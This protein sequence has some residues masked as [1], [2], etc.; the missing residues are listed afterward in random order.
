MELNQEKLFELLFEA[1]G[2]GIILV[3]TKGIIQM[4]NERV[5]NMFG[6]SK[7]EL[8]G[9]HL[10]IFV[11]KPIRARHTEHLQKYFS[12]PKSRYMGI[13]LHLEAA[14]KDDGLF[15]VEISLNHFEAAGNTYVIALITDVTERKLQEQKILK[16]NEELEQ[17]V[18][19][20]TEQLS[21]SEQLY[22]TIA[23]NF[24]DG[25]INVFDR[26]YNYLFVEGK[27]FLNPHT[28]PLSLTGTNF[29]KQLP[30]NQHEAVTACLEKAFEGKSC[31]VDIKVVDKF[32]TMDTTPLAESD[33]SIPKV[34]SIIKNI[35]PL[36]QTEIK[37]K[38]NLQKERELNR[39]KFRF[40]SMASHEFRTPLSTILSSV[41]L[42]SRY[43]KEEDQAKR[44]KH[45]NRIKSS[46]SNLTI[47]LNDFLSIEK[48]ESGRITVKTETFDLNHIC[49]QVIEDL[50]GVLKKGQDIHFAPAQ[51]VHMVSLDKQLL[52]N[53]IINLLSNASKYSDEDQEIVLKIERA[54]DQS[55]SIHVIDRG[56]GIPESEQ[57]HLF[58]RFF[59]AQ[60]ALNI[61]GTGLG[62][63]ITKKYTE[64]MG[65]HISIQSGEGIGTHIQLNFPPNKI[66]S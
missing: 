27:E 46:I 18:A 49:A 57:E 62:L 20:R 25:S 8:I 26:D 2:E 42:I 47:I 28:T 43:T 50:R 40:V 63:N 45:I 31:S 35:T 13:G 10:N 34:L 29:L 66:E 39:M 38:R 24:P 37:I 7:D 61:Q 36:K 54:A 6:Y 52:G 21:K 48:L 64:L 51:H 56:I 60:N 3:D 4:A 11:P 12:A 16:L 19:L 33:G 1:A 65:G 14:T 23:K 58:E 30:K 55:F 5:T 41:S 59:R 53:A 17:R 9:Q 44:D 22:S 32:F 15:P